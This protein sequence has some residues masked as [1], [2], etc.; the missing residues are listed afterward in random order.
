LAG[1]LQT[2]LVSSQRSPQ[3]SQLD[4][5]GPTS[6]GRGGGE[7]KRGGVEGEATGKEVGVCVMAFFLGG[8][9]VL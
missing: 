9:D 7:G 1:P 6:N 8:V 4:L 5:R 3:T 2:P